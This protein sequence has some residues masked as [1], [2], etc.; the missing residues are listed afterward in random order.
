VLRI[1]YGLE[2]KEMSFKRLRV[3]FV[4][5]VRCCQ[6]EDFQCL[7]MWTSSLWSVRSA[8]YFTSSQ[9]AQANVVMM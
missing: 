3:F 1:V 4:V 6:C 8:D 7:R 2:P 9:Q 5:L